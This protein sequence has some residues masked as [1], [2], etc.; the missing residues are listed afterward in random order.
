MS[1][2]SERDLAQ[3]G[4]VQAQQDA[5]NTKQ[6][7]AEESA[8]ITQPANTALTNVTEQANDLASLQKATVQNTAQVNQQQKDAAITQQK[9]ENVRNN[10][11][12]QLQQQIKNRQNKNQLINGYKQLASDEAKMKYDLAAQR[13]SQAQA[14]C[15][16]AVKILQGLGAA[17]SLIPGVGTLVGAGISAGATALGGVVSNN[18]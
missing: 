1:L 10:Y 15:A 18:I 16:N 2:H 6:Q 13:L 5:A 9:N 3:S 8:D 11:S 4:W 7:L 14:N 12:T 17:V